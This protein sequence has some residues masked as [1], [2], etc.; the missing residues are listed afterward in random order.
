MKALLNFSLALNTLLL[1]SMLIQ[2]Q[3]NHHSTQATQNNS[4]SDWPQQIG[5]DVGH[6]LQ[7]GA[8]DE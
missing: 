7:G 2:C 5:K 6:C 1:A 3:A 8:E 4:Q